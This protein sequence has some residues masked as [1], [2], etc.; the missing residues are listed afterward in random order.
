MEPCV[1]PGEVLDQDVEL[2]AVDQEI[3]RS[4]IASEDHAKAGMKG[5]LERRL[6]GSRTP[7]L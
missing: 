1:D 3:G 2:D 6:T 7:P 5:G 4:E